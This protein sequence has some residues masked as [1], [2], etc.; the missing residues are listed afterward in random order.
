MNDEIAVGKG[1]IWRRVGGL[2]DEFVV[3][4]RSRDFFEYAPLQ[5]F[6]HRLRVAGG[7]KRRQP[8]HAVR[9]SRRERCRG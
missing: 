2:R 8:D 6:P 9:R 5:A 3:S 4:V 7:K 1:Q